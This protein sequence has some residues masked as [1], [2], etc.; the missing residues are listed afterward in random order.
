[1]TRTVLRL[2]SSARHD[3]STSRRLTDEVVS[4]LRASR[5]VVR[6][7]DAEPLPFVSGTW[8]SG[9]FTPEADRAPEQR[10][11]LAL[12]DTLVA[13]L[14]AADVVVIGMP[15]YN[16]TVPASLKAWMDQVARVGVTFRYTESGPVGLLE[17]KRAI[18]A[19]ASGGTEVGSPIDFATPYA[20]HFLGFLGIDDVEVVASDRLMADPDASRARAE[21]D[22]DRLAA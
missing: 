12:S 9:T 22:L 20:K 7:L 3:G 6:D 18:L 4:R 14:Q 19:V 8:A 13:E 17:G 1:M 2:D 16:F 10:A 15:I 5:V 11:A 21:A